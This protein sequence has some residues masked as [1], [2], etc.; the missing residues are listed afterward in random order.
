MKR[1]SKPVGHRVTVLPL[2]GVYHFMLRFITSLPTASLAD[3]G[4]GF[5]AFTEGRAEYPAA[6]MCVECDS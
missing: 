4:D 1:Y 2:N 5:A 3:G 6:T